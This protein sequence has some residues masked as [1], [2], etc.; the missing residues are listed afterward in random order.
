MRRPYGFIGWAFL[1][2]L[3][4]AMLAA[5]PSS[6]SLAAAN[7]GGKTS[8]EGLRLGVHGDRTRFVVDLAAPAD[9]TIFTLANPYRVVID[10][11]GATFDLVPDALPRSRGGISNLRFGLFKADV[12]RIVIDAREPLEVQKAFQIPPSGASGDRLVI[13]LVPTDRTTFLASVG[14]PAVKSAAKRAQT[15]PKVKSAPSVV[16]PKGR[17]LKPVVVI[18]PGHGGIDPGAIGRSGIYEKDI[19]L[20]AAN[21]LKDLLDAAGR[22]EVVMTRRKDVFV[23]LKERVA[24][25]REA[26]GD[27]FVSLHADSLPS[28]PKLRGAS[29]YTLSEDASDAE[30]AALAKSENSS[31]LLAGVDLGGQTPDVQNILIDL[32]Q[33]ETMNESIRFARVAV[34]HL[35]KRSKLINRPHRFAGFRVLKAPDVPSVLVEM[36]FL[37]N[38]HDE[39]NLRKEAYR[40][41]LMIGLAES[42]D[43]YFALNR[44]LVANE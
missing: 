31:D 21:I 41:K 28:S 13:D 27:L 9:Y 39:A 15:P 32:A 44:S 19:V 10:L 34:N 38:R 6:P 2:V 12:A 30:A 24:M 20:S 43:G 35:Q 40:K 7:A 3:A 29:V 14:A 22:Y 5:A 4:G 36:G 37:S 8:I 18:D 26:G 23:P 16:V 42:I 33:R 11:K 25:A 17:T 1:L